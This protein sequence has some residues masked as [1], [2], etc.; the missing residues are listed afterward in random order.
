MPLIL[1]FVLYTGRRKFTHST[2]FFD[3]FDG[4]K[5]LAQE[6]LRTV[7]FSSLFFVKGLSLL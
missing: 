2:A 7:H 1:P 4:D 5:G 6:L 3:L